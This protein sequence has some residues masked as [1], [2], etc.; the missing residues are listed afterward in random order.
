MKECAHYWTTTDCNIVAEYQKGVREKYLAH[1]DYQE[2]SH[3][4]EGRFVPHDRTLQIVF[5]EKILPAA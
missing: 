2:C 3:C 1:G 4:P 5:C